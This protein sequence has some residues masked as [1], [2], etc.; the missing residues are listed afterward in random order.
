MFL[1]DHFL[2][3]FPPISPAKILGCGHCTNLSPVAAPALKSREWQW[4]WGNGI[5]NSSMVIILTMLR[6]WPERSGCP[7]VLLSDPPHV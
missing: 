5:K 1:S 6:G 2:S 3:L 7:A 4:I